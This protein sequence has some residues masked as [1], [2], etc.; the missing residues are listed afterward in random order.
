MVVTFLGFFLIFSRIRI[1]PPLLPEQLYESILSQF[2]RHN[3]LNQSKND[4]RVSCICETIIMSTRVRYTYRQPDAHAHYH[5]SIS[6]LAMR[7]FSAL[8]ARTALRF[9]LKIR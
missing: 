6:A 5:Q 4:T 8:I 3:R 9:A 7:I 1:F 2:P